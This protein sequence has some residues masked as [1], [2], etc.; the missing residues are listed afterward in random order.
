MPWGTQP[1]TLPKGKNALASARTFAEEMLAKLVDRY[2]VPKLYLVT[3]V[4]LA[5][6]ATLPVRTGEQQASLLYVSVY[7]GTLDI[8]LGDVTPSTT[9]IPL[10]RVTPTGFPVPFALPP[11]TYKFTLHAANAT[12]CRA[13]VIASSA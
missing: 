1:I 11:D 13:C 6:D 9:S 2:V 5:S 4:D 8:Y 7:S 12:A 10:T 3:P